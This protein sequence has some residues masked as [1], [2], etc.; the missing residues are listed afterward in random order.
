MMSTAKNL[1]TI[2]NSN[3]SK[4]RELN[5]AKPKAVV[6]FYSYVLAFL[7]KIDPQVAAA[8]KENIIQMKSKFTAVQNN[9]T[10]RIGF[11]EA[12][13]LLS[14]GGAGMNEADFQRFEKQLFMQIFETWPVY[15]PQVKKN[16]QDFK[17]IKSNHSISVKKT[18]WQNPCKQCP[19]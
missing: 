6:R 18:F 16:M 14:F 15:A 1:S 5:M 17:K 12:L 7:D 8:I 9:Q 4:A 10:K 19:A 13:K 2:Q 3:A 11:L